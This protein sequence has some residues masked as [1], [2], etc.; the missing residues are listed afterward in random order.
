M[1]KELLRISS[2]L[3]L[4]SLSSNAQVTAAEKCTRARVQFKEIF[5]AGLS[6]KF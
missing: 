3:F 1:K 5:G 6:F 4:L 2:F